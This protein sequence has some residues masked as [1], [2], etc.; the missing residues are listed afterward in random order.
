MQQRWSDEKTRATASLTFGE[1]Q[2]KDHLIRLDKDFLLENAA[3][4]F[5]EKAI[6]N[7]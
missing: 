5:L 7:K 4:M 1:K 2:N 6:H 3:M